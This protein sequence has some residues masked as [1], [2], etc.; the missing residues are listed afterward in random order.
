MTYGKT[1]LRRPAFALAAAAL[2]PLGGCHRQPAQPAV[3]IA[4]PWVRLPAVP[5]G[6]GAGY[7]TATSAADDILLGVA[8]PGA[9]I[10]MHESMTHSGMA[11]MRP[12]ADVALPAGGTVSF[13]PG[14]KH[15]MIHGLDPKLKKGGTIALIFRF[16]SAPPVTAA[17]RLVGPGDG[18]PA[19]AGH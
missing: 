4:Q 18:P 12:L 16:R 8:A 10:E 11:S 9:R 17:A 6:E 14:G 13:A 2:L 7:F 5:G 15:L 3:S 1:N 19:D